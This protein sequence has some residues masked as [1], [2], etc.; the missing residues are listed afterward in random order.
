[1]IATRETVL[2]DLRSIEADDW[3][4]EDAEMLLDILLEAVDAVG[5]YTWLAFYRPELVG[6][7]LALLEEGDSRR[8]FA[9]AR[10]MVTELS[11][12]HG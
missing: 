7:P 11:V 5:A 8:V 3:T 9:A 2:R 6:V 10:R 12:D 4:H 1:M